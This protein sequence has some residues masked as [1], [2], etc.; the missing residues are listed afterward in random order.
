MS[1]Q[2]EKPKEVGYD[3]DD[4]VESQLSNLNKS[5]FGK[6]QFWCILL[7]LALI[8]FLIYRRQQRKREDQNLQSQQNDEENQALPEN[9]NNQEQIQPIVQA[10]EEKVVDN[11]E[12][13]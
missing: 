1:E 3:V 12:A 5:F 6:P 10:E 13:K 11:C 9:L 4:K 2:A 8:A 7:L